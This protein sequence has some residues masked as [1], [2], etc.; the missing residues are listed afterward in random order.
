MSDSEN[1]YFAMLDGHMDDYDNYGILDTRLLTCAAC[2]QERI[3]AGYVA[4]PGVRGSGFYARHSGI[5]L[6]IAKKVEFLSRMCR[7]WEVCHWL[8]DNGIQGAYKACAVRGLTGEGNGFKLHVWGAAGRVLVT[9]RRTSATPLFQNGQ[10]KPEISMC[11]D[12]TANYCR[13]GIQ[14]IY[15]TYEEALALLNDSHAAF[16]ELKPDEGVAVA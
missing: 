5:L 14:G 4:Y 2:L 12:E 1:A 10:Y 8:G 9:L 7:W 6:G 15:A 3:N 16:P 13:G 11:F